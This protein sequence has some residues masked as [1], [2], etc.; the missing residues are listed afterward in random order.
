MVN[1]WKNQV[2]KKQFFHAFFMHF[3]ISIGFSW[4]NS[5]QIRIKAMVEKCFVG[6]TKHFVFLFQIVWLHGV[7]SIIYF[8]IKKHVEATY[9]G[10]HALSWSKGSR[11]KLKVVKPPIRRCNKQK[12]LMQCPFPP[13]VTI[14]ITSPMFKEGSIQFLSSWMSFQFESIEGSGY[15][16]EWRAVQAVM[17][18]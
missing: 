12:W 5:S 11:W 8:T 6:T 13:P 1:A 18:F 7:A 10:L 14:W 17:Q 3:H 9:W 16:L 2:I 15:Y 4:D